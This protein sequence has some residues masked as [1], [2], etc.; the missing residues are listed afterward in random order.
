MCSVGIET[1]GRYIQVRIPPTSY[2]MLNIPFLKMITY[3]RQFK[4]L[5]LLSILIE[6]ILQLIFLRLLHFLK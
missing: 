5:Q 4:L 1:W 6:K 3:F 2:G